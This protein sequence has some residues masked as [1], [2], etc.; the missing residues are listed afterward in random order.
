MSG[1]SWSDLSFVKRSKE[2]SSVFNCLD[3]PKTP[4]QIKNECKMQ[5]SRASRALKELTNRGLV[6]CLTPREVRGRYYRLNKKG[7]RL[8][9]TLKR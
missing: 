6:E 4:T 9:E 8:A 7:E 2:R 1:S 5:I 3:E